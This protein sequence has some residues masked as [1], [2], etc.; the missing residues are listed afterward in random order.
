MTDDTK[1]FLELLDKFINLSISNQ[2]TLNVLR[3]NLKEIQDS[4]GKSDATLFS[5]LH[6]LM[7][8][9][10]DIERTHEKLLA[11]IDTYTKREYTEAEIEELGGPLREIHELTKNCSK[12]EQLECT[13][14]IIETHAFVANIKKRWKWIVAFITAGAFIIT[15][16]ERIVK[17]ILYLHGL[18]G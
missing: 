8:E 12:N 6:R 15:F 14:K 7:A 18:G 17:L 16:A 1:K 4:V 11:F 3:T 5:L 2:T 10:K 9:K 13:E